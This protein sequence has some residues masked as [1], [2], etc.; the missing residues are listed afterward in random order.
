MRVGFGS[1]AAAAIPK[2]R[3]SNSNS[4]ENYNILSVPNYLIKSIQIVTNY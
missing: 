1:I 3:N 4:N 2:G